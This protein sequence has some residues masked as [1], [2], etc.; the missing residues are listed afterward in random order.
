M[1][2]SDEDW[3]VTDEEERRERRKTKG[4]S[5]EVSEEEP[6]QEQEMKKRLADVI[7]VAKKQLADDADSWKKRPLVKSNGE[8]REIPCVRCEKQQ[9]TYKTD[10]LCGFL[11]SVLHIM[12]A[13]EGPGL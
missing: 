2:L 6:E 12:F 13:R 1:R 8:E 5:K 10:D 11:I 4:K 9:R 3:E 7:K